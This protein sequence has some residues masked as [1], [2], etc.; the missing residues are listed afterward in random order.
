M[1]RDPSPVARQV[2]RDRNDSEWAAARP[3]Q[4][5][6]EPSRRRKA[7]A[8]DSATVDLVDWLSENPETIEQIQTVG[9]IL[10]GPVVRQLDE[11]FGGSEPR[12]ARRKLTEHFWCDLLVAAAEAIEEFSKALDQVP[13]YMTA[14]IMRSRAA[15][16]RSPFVNGLVGLAARTAWEPIKNMIHTTGVKEL[17]RTCR[18]LSVLICP[19]PENHKAVRDGAL[20]P[21]AQEGLLETSKERLEQVFPADWVRRLREGLDQA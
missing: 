2:A 4:K 5:R 14:V 7:A 8:T 16:R 17:Q 15:E 11:K 13:E 21:L 6:Q 18:I 20:L 9:N 10:A 19:A 12:S 1:A 3:P